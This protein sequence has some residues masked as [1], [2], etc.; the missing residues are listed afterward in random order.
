MKKKFISI[1]EWGSVILPNS[2][3]SFSTISP[4]RM[5][6]GGPHFAFTW[7]GV[8]SGIS[9]PSV[10]VGTIFGSRLDPKDEMPINTD[11]WLVFDPNTNGDFWLEDVKEKSGIPDH[12]GI[13]IPSTFRNAPKTIKGLFREKID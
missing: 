10:P 6:D 4:L 13:G 2:G 11:K 8:P 9:G 7:A 1:K 3:T 12:H 5:I